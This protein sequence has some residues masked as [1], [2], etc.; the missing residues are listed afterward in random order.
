M[1]EDTQEF[2]STERADAYLKVAHTVHTRT[3][4]LPLWEAYREVAID[5]Q[6]ALNRATLEVGEYKQFL[7]R[8]RDIVQKYN[9][10]VTA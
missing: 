2:D 10:L 5:L 9:E 6:C 8:Y 1:I 3:D 4:E 7:A